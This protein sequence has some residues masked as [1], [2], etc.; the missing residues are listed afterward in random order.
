MIDT[1]CPLL[2]NGFYINRTGDVYPCCHQRPVRIGNL[3]DHRLSDLINGPSATRAR[4]DSLRGRLSCFGSCTLL[5]KTARGSLQGRNTRMDYDQVKRLH[6]SFGEACNIRCIMCAHPERHAADPILLGADVLVRNIDPRP[7]EDF[8]LQGGE[9]LLLRPCLDYMTHLESIGKTYTILTNGLLIDQQMAE[10]LALHAKVVSI[11]LNGATK[12]VHETVNRG[13]RYE[14]V[15]GNI[16]RLRHARD[17]HATGVIISGRMTLTPQ[18]VHEIPLFLETFRSLGFDRVNFGFVREQVPN[19]L[20]RD[21]RLAA[22]LRA[23]VESFLEL[24]G[25]QDV[26]TLRLRQLGLVSSEPVVPLAPL[27]LRA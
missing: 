8:I 7:V 18:N 12:A 4:Y 20:S 25:G 27:S 21:R 23:E 9:P 3:R 16:Q 24:H 17:N 6:I 14:R 22:A 1:W 10:R 2:W 11:S 5:D 19:L 13:S 26:D 15:L